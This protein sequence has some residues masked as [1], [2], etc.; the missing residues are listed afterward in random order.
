M[1]PGFYSITS[2]ATAGSPV[3]I[4][5]NIAD[6]N[7]TVHV[8][9]QNAGGKVQVRSSGGSWQTVTV[10]TDIAVTAGQTLQLASAEKLYRSMALGITPVEVAVVVE[11]SVVGLS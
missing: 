2:A 3:I 5:P 10:P 8:H 1:T 7:Y 9:V 11:I 4:T 6:K